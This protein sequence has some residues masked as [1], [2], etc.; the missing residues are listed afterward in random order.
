[1]SEQL[2]LE[3]KRYSEEDAPKPTTVDYLKRIFCC[4]P[5]PQKED[6]FFKVEKEGDDEAVFGNT[7]NLIYIFMFYLQQTS[8]TVV[9]GVQYPETWENLVAWLK[10]VFYPQFEVNFNADELSLILTFVYGIPLFLYFWLY[11]SAGGF[12]S[13]TQSPYIFSWNILVVS[14]LLTV[15]S[16]VLFALDLGSVGGPLT[17]VTGYTYLANFLLTFRKIYINKVYVPEK[18]LFR[19]TEFTARI[20]YRTA[21]VPFIQFLLSLFFTPIASAWLNHSLASSDSSISIP[22]GIA[23]GVILILYFVYYFV[24]FKVAKHY[25]SSYFLYIGISVATLAPGTFIDVFRGYTEK[26]AFFPL[27]FLAEKL[28]L[29]VS[30]IFLGDIT[31]N[32]FPVSG[33]TSL[34]VLLIS[35]FAIYFVLPYEDKLLSRVDGLTRLSNLLLIATALS[36]TESAQEDTEQAADIVM[37]VVSTITLLFWIFVFRKIIFS[38]EGWVQYFPLFVIA[39][40]IK[41]LYLGFQF[42][43]TWKRVSTLKEAQEILDG[44]SGVG[45]TAFEWKRMTNNQQLISLC[46]K[47]KQPSPVDLEQGDPIVFELETWEDNKALQRL[48]RIGLL[49]VQVKSFS[50]THT[51][52]NSIGLRALSEAKVL[53]TYT[54]LE[55]IKMIGVGLSGEAGEIFMNILLDEEVKV[56]KLDFFGALVEEN[57]CEV[58]SK[59][60]ATNQGLESLNMGFNPTMGKGSLSVLESLLD[61][62]ANMKEILFHNSALDDIHGDILLELFKTVNSLEV[63]QV[64]KNKF[65]EEMVNRFFETVRTVDKGHSV[66]VNFSQNS[67]R[68]P[69]VQALY[70]VNEALYSAQQNQNLNFKKIADL[71]FFYKEMKEFEF[72]ESFSKENCFVTENGK[73]IG[74][75]EYLWKVAN[76]GVVSCVA[77]AISI[78]NKREKEEVKN[79]IKDQSPQGLNF[80]AA[81][82]LTLCQDKGNYRVPETTSVIEKLY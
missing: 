82:I 57:A 52:V 9:D 64:E 48:R 69:G 28:M 46:C 38:I 68:D 70:F 75:S 77:A 81:D 12:I 3:N 34:L 40:N 72:K 32:G 27:I 39:R 73:L 20:S 44:R 35:F 15:G 60:I 26:F 76:E 67:G 4:I 8:L 45:V 11:I 13:W 66:T 30:D 42:S 62:T 10:D 5:L 56:P 63:F 61:S 78:L 21:E 31:I 7:R 79:F 2:V 19:Y 65:S 74:F 80:A 71:G 58:L 55:T 36:F 17:V 25:N 53:G 33:L 51:K 24:L 22:F 54:G 49:S 16:I 37:L 47:R 41:Q 18:M 50:L 59:Y 29:L 23:G 14:M 6:P 43:Q 1:M